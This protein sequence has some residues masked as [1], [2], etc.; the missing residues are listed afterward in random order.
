MESVPFTSMLW[1]DSDK[2]KLYSNKDNTTSSIKDFD[3]TL[4]LAAD[5]SRILEPGSEKIMEYVRM[6]VD[7][8]GRKVKLHGRNIK[9]YSIGVAGERKNLYDYI[10]QN[11]ARQIAEQ[12]K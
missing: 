4:P 11:I 12:K 2:N 6:T 5:L 10:Y 9:N 7:I 1:R 3:V 8:N